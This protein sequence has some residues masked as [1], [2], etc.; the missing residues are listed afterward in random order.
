MYHPP[1]L[2]PLRVP[3][4]R[5]SPALEPATLLSLVLAILV[6]ASAAGSAIIE[7]SKTEPTNMELKS[8]AFTAGHPIPSRH[9]CD[10]QDASPPLSWSEPPGGT[11]SFALVSDDPDAPG[12]MWVHWVVW[13]IPA[14]ARALAESLP[15]KE[16]LPDGTKQGTTDFGRIG[17]GG[18]CPPSGTH[19]YF[20]KLYA[21][22]TTLVLPA[23]T[24]KEDL[25]RAMRGHILA[26]PELMGT[27][28]RR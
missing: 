1:M 13:N 15:K 5:A 26:Q 10:G 2:A 19:R 9:T 25:E 24:T 3:G 14:S 27:Y 22:D 11:R 12:G 23:S 16:S 21:L 28:K 20:F 18:P 7:P 8:Q 4:I 6:H 17:Y